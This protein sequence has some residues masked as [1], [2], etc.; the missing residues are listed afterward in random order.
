MGRTVSI[1]AQGFS[2]IRKNQYFYV[3]KTA[4]IK[5]WWESGDQVTL[6]ARPRRF[7]KTLNM[8]MLEC[9]FS[10]KYAGRG[11]LFEGLKIWEE[12]KYR[13]LQGTYPVIFLSFAD[14]KGSNFKDTRDGI[15]SCLAEAFDAHNYLLDSNV[16]TEQEKAAF[17]CLGQAV[18]GDGN[19]VDFITND[20]IA[21]SIKK[22]ARWL[23][24]YYGKNV[25]ILL[26]EYDTPMQEAWL[27][28][29]WDEIVSLF[30]SMFN[31]TFKT[32]P[33]LER[34][35]MT[36]ITRVSKESIFSDLN[37]LK[38]ITTTSSQ[39]GDCFGFTEKEVFDALDEM[40]LSNEKEGVKAWYDG[41]TFGPHTDIYNPWS[42]TN[43]LDNRDYGTYW[44]DT[45]SN[46]L[47][48]RLLQ[49]SDAKRKE[50]LKILLQGGTLEKEIDE[51]IIFSQLEK[52]E[53]AL[54]SLMLASGYLRVAS[55]RLDPW[56]KRK[57]YS[58]KLTNFE[59]LVM[60][61]DMIRDWFDTGSATSG[62]FTGALL[63]GDLEYMNE[64]MNEIALA[65][66]SSF[67]AGSHPSEKSQPE[68]FY[69]GFVLGLLVELRGRYAVNSNRESGLG[70]YDVMLEPLKP[71]DPAF[72]LEFKVHNP[73]KESD[74]EATVAAALQQ[75]KD[76]NYAASLEAK[77]IPADRIRTYGFAFEGK[78]VLIG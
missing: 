55:Y 25:I 52:K 47:I 30:R 72:I 26:D 28:G 36:G 63:A 78:N 23:S 65:T 66:F 61:H 56:S 2:D 8:N 41:F 75:I 31:A 33:Y 39:Y 14:V 13:N 54:W 59:V 50:D 60:F 34:G 27:N 67:D 57:I 69:H 19:W 43:F 48:S 21:R 77:G 45:S 42:I 62:D 32:N 58:L 20:T 51:Q 38:V 49:V 53:S 4:F 16:L 40:D 68:R 5:E 15:I 3:D 10:S 6:I 76:R 44:A 24:L 46:G 70:R 1:G 71:G 29:Y 74:L 37:N 73:K 22:L 64:Y 17:A 7:G 12:E 11:D 18:P 35:V 9:F